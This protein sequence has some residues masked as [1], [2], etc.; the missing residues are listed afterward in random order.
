LMERVLLSNYI[1]PSADRATPSDSST[2]LRLLRVKGRDQADSLYQGVRKLNGLISVRVSTATNIVTLDVDARH[3]EL[4]AAIANRFIEYL[5]AFNTQSRQSQ[6]GEQRRFVE[7]RVADGERELR[8]AEAELRQFY[9][10]N[11][12][13]QQSPQLTFEEGRLRRQVDIR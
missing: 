1:N 13:W 6:A 12:S 8:D 5:N 2:L 10:R 3:P 4:A 9:E 7:Q 11:R